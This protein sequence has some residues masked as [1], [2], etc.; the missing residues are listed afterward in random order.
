MICCDDVRDYVNNAD[1]WEITMHG[2]YTYERMCI[3]VTF[4]T[5]LAGSKW[6]SSSLM[7]EDIFSLSGTKASPT[8]FI[9]WMHSMIAQPSSE[10][11]KI[12]HDRWFK[13]KQNRWFTQ[14]SYLRQCLGHDLLNNTKLESPLT[15]TLCNNHRKRNL[16]PA[17]T[18]V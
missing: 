10:S 12:V 5:Y 9:T 13:K 6:T 16:V 2:L 17:K 14:V 4:R 3:V 1:C 18:W 8:P 11:E 7:F 15:S